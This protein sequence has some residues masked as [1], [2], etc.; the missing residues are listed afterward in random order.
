MRSLDYR[1]V[2][3]GIETLAK[4]EEVE[5]VREGMFV[6]PKKRVEI[7]SSYVYTPA[8]QMGSGNSCEARLED[9]QTRFNAQAK[10]L[11]R[12]RSSKLP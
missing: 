8:E 4:M 10:E 7:R 5:T 12:G 3:A 6:M 2:V 1:E 11:Q 9:L